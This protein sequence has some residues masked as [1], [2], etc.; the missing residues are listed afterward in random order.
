MVRKTTTIFDTGTTLIVGDENGISKLFARIPG[1]SQYGDGMYTSAYFQSN[2]AGGLA[3]TSDFLS[4]FLAISTLPFP[5]ML[6]GQ[7]SPSLLLHL[8]LVLSP[9]IL[10]PVW[11]VRPRLRLSTVVSWPVGFPVG[12]A[13]CDTDFWIL[14]DVF[15]QNVYSAWDVGNARIG[16]ATLA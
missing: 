2:A 8:I 12:N 6:V 1:A 15:L 4:Q 10:V 3:H 9:T 11:L 16:F 13:D 5:L 14:G 7:R